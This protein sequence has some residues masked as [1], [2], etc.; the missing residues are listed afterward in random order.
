V[1]DP[2]PELRAIFCEALD[3]ESLREQ[4]EYLDR[5]CQGRPALRARV[6]M[7]LRANAEAGGFL[8][9][10]DD[11]AAAPAAESA[12]SERP[13]TRLGPYQL[14][15]QIG[16]GG[17]GVVWLAEQEQ[18]VRRKVALKIIKPGLDSKQILARFEAERQA[19]ALMD[20]PNIAKVLDAGTLGESEPRAVDGRGPVGRPYFVMELVKG[21]PITTFCDQN[22]LTPKERLELFVPVCQAIQHAHTKGIIH[23]DVKP[24]NVLVALYDDVPVPKVID[25][26]VAKAVDQ[27]LTEQTL[28]TRVGQ[29]IGTLEYMSP[30]Q[31]EFNALDIDTRSDVYSLGVLLYELLTGTTPLD[32]KRLGGVPLLELL[33]IIREEEPPK[34]STRLSESETLPGVAAARNTEP[35]QLARLVRGELDWIVMKAL[36]K[37]RARRYDTASSLAHDVERYLRDEAVEAGPPTA[38]YRLRKFLGRHRGPVLAAALLLLALLGGTLGTAWGLVQARQALAAEAKQRH[39]A[40]QA[41]AL[42]RERLGEATAERAVAGAINDFLR[43]DLLGQADVSNQ[44]FGAGRPER[45]PKVTVRELLDRAAGTVAERFA[46]QPLTEAAVRRTLAETYGGLGEYR[47]ARP[48]AERAVALWMAQRGADHPDT[49]HGKVILGLL[50]DYQAEYDRAEQLFLEVLRSETAQ[51]EPDH[52][53]ISS[54]RMGLAG[55]YLAQKKYDQ[56]ELLCREVL[57][58]LTTRLGGDDYRTLSARNNLAIL[59]LQQKK[60][61]AAEPLLREVV[62]AYTARQGADHSA[63]LTAQGNL[64]NVYWALG[65]REESVALREE[66]LRGWQR[67]SGSDHLRTIRTALILADWYSQVGRLAEAETLFDD[68]LP[69]ARGQLGFGHGITQ[70]ALLTAVRIYEQQKKPAKAEPLLRALADHV[71]EQFGTEAPAYAGQLNFLGKNLL[72]QQ[73]YAAAE[74][75]LRACLAIRVKVGPAAWATSSTQAQLGASLLG[76]K[77]YTEAEPLLRQG[78]E[79]LKR[80]D[81]LPAPNPTLEVLEWLVQ[82]YDATG[83]HDKAAAYRKELEEARKTRS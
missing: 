7:L 30:E 68:W 73:K 70:Q 67:S 51:R 28:C 62:Q 45:N 17:M 78:Y 56:A 50:C 14:L 53:S 46:G 36:D 20:H 33:R 71:K 44:P 10:A 61:S 79:G 80:Q 8:Q 15:E 27:R 82:L 60:F 3:R 32:Q 49:L 6:E 42:A 55:V 76:Q 31:A 37:D 13:G 9:E 81:K 66:M 1:A 57:Q 58:A 64:A 72:Q 63:T 52:L 47:L 69:R 43:R 23:R 22:H 35:A 39:Q 19:L 21:V 18:P 74:P 5:V 41:E 77:K 59:Y 26:G 54:A 40:E 34:P 4:A 2:Q 25:F 38:A 11:R 16:E 83:Q 75:V 65:R 24:S 48:H 12:G 29:V